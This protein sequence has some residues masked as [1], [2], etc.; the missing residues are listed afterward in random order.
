VSLGTVGVMLPGTEAPAVLQAGGIAYA[1]II[2]VMTG[3]AV[4]LA[5]AE[6]RYV[7][8]AV[9]ALLFWLSDLMLGASLFATVGGSLWNDAIWVAYI[10][11]QGMIVLGARR[12]VVSGPATA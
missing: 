9:G 12:N 8:L 2:S 4:A 7:V 1:A 10:A 11:G 6:R 5:R 3:L